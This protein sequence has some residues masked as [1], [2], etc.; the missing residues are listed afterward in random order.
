MSPSVRGAEGVQVVALLAGTGALS[1]GL[2][3]LG[4]GALWA[5]TGLGALE[6]AI[7]ALVVSAAVLADLSRPLF[8]WLAPVALGRQVP[9]E[10][11][12][13]FGPKLAAALYG[14]RLGVG[15]LTILSSWA[16]WAALVVGATLGPWT[17]AAVGASFALSRTLTTVAAGYGVVTGIGM[18][19]RIDSLDRWEPAVVFA[20]T[21]LLCAAALVLVLP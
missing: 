16:W 12:R 3:G 9:A 7:V 2:V 14:T 17:S 13:L 4:A 20:S 19:H 18:H 11:G 15:P 8:P 10:W 5:A 21:G 6:P 1:G